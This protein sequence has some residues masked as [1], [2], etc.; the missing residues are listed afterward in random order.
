MSEWTRALHAAPAVW[1]CGPWSVSGPGPIREKRRGRQCAQTFVYGEF[2]RRR[3][4]FGRCRSFSGALAVQ[5]TSQGCVANHMHRIGLSQPRRSPRRPPFMLRTNGNYLC[6][7]H[8]HRDSFLVSP[9]WRRRSGGSIARTREVRARASSGLTNLL[10]GPPGNQ[11]GEPHALSSSP[12]V[13]VGHLR[14]TAPYG[15]SRAL[16]AAR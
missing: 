4:L 5:K 13:P 11:N 2:W 12:L 3:P 8:S 7:V 6:P 10:S 16:R 14:F 9:R 1:I 15:A